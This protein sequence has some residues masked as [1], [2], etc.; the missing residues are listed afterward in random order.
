MDDVGEPVST[1]NAYGPW[2]ATDTFVN[3]AMLPGDCTMVRGTVAAGVPVSRDPGG[4]A[5][6]VPR[7]R[8]WLTGAGPSAP[9]KVKVC[10][11]RSSFIALNRPRMSDPSTPS[12]RF[13]LQLVRFAL[14]IS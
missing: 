8:A 3:V 1:K 13:P 9:A 2:F 12:T 5:P 7:M 11:V 4:V 10:F 14:T 6:A